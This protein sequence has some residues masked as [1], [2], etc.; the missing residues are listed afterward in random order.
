MRLAFSFRYVF[1]YYIGKHLFKA[2]SRVPVVRS[3]SGVM[4]TETGIKHTGTL[5]INLFNQYLL[6]TL[7]PRNSSRH[8][9]YSID[10][11]I[12]NA[13]IMKHIIYKSL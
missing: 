2:L 10:K 11:T 7:F 9:G 13:T 4:D 5:N 6:N 8:R 12:K 3:L 1:L